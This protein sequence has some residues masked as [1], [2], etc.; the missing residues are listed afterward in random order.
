MWSSLL[1]D[2][3]GFNSASGHRKKGKNFKS[4]CGREVTLEG[5]KPT[6]YSISVRISRG[7]VWGRGSGA[8]D[9]WLEASGVGR[10]SE[11][12]RMR[13]GQGP[14]L[15]VGSGEV[16]PQPDPRGTLEHN[17]HCSDWLPLVTGGWGG[18]VKW[19]GAG[20]RGGGG[21]VDV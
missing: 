10:G 14:S 21:G 1:R 15:G 13:Q 11:A 7:R 20:D 9:W 19:G 5:V 16:P 8:L 2:A 4:Y 18:G 12:N 6:R 3:G 17:L